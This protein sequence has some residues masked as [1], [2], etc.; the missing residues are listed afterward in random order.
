MVFHFESNLPNI[1]MCTLIEIHVKNSKLLFFWMQALAIV[2]RSEQHVLARQTRG[3]A[4]GSWKAVLIEDKSASSDVRSEREFYSANKIMTPATKT[5]DATLEFVARF[6]CRTSDW[7]KRYV[8][9]RRS[10]ASHC[11]PRPCSPLLGYTRVNGWLLRRLRR[12]KLS[13]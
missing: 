9:D 2:R 6:V 12:K 5:R 7:S 4:F 10:V 11:R 13:T 1:K 3:T 8:A